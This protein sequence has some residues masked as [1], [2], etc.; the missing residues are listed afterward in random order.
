MV[1]DREIIVEPRGMGGERRSESPYLER[2]LSEY[3]MRIKSELVESFGTI[4][5]Q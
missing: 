1:V 4:C 5:L 3:L 2:G